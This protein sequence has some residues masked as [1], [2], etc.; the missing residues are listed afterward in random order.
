MCVRADQSYA[1]K[2]TCCMPVLRAEAASVELINMTIS[3]GDKGLKQPRSLPNGRRRDTLGT[4]GV[5]KLHSAVILLHDIVRILAGA[6]SFGA[7]SRSS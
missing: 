7:G 5:S 2:G 1:G 3:A 6:N 4:G